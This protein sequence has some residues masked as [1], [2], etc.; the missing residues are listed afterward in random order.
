MKKQLIVVIG[1]LL[2][3]GVSYGQV[4]TQSKITASINQENP[5]LDASSYVKFDPNVGR[6]LYFPTTDLKTWEFKTDLIDPETFSTYFDGMVVY[7][8]GEGAPTTEAS[9]GG[10]R[11]N[12]TRG[13][14][15]FKNPNQN[16]PDGSIEN[17]EWVRLSDTQMLQQ[18]GLWTNDASGKVVKLKSLTDGGERAEDKNI[19]I[20][21]EGKVGVG[22]QKPE[23]KLDVAGT[24]KI[25]D[26]TQG[27]GKVL[28]SDSKGNASWETPTM[29]YAYATGGGE[30]DEEFPGSL[31]PAN[32][33]ETTNKFLYTGMKITLPT[34]GKYA[35]LLDLNISLTPSLEVKPLLS[36]TTSYD[37]QKNRLKLGE[38]IDIRG[39]FWDEILPEGIDSS[40]TTGVPMKN[41]ANSM[42]RG[43]M[44][45]PSIMQRVSN[46]MYIEN[47]TSGPKTFY[48]YGN[49][50]I[51]N[52]QP[53]E[54]TRYV[55]ELGSGRWA[56]ESLVAFKIGE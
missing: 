51:I 55:Y 56:E 15:Y 17:G 46:T 43:V 24:V 12:L 50:Q 42:Y 47:P 35:V 27:A 44:Y 16:F 11:K 39:T 36:Y 48:F 9:K 54:P 8:I 19:Y 18:E 38:A 33:Y 5:F 14:Y 29:S 22:T 49:A 7:N 45:F 23:A 52:P 32:L 3:G 20:T 10:I 21:D 37:A 25:V 41:K 1:V 6:G 30:R 28:T 26:G 2:I 34:K 40:R 31:L 4:K 53:G 13:F